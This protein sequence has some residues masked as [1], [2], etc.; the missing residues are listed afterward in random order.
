MWQS[1]AQAHDGQ[2]NI[3][4]TIQSNTCIVDTDSQNMTVDMGNVASRQFSQ[5]GATSTPQP[6]M[7]KLVKCG[8]A[9]S[10]VSVTFKGTVDSRD[11]QLLAIDSGSAAA[12]GMGIAI[13]DLNRQ[14]V[15]LNASSAKYPLTPGMQSVDLNF[16][17]EYRA[18]GDTV[19]AGD[20]NAT[21]SFVLN[22]A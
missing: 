22:Y 16:F 1:V 4:G 17:A 21:A 20:A 14:V 8:D 5:A 11:N 3:T 7:I 2:I 6:F 19:K 15:P 12:T 13:L 18:N 9:A 10:G